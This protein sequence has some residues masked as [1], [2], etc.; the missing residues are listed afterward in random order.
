MSPT[1]TH[2]ITP[3]NKPNGTWSAAKQRKSL[4][5]DILVRSR[6]SWTGESRAEG[7]NGTHAR[8]FAVVGKSPKSSKRFMCP[9]H[10]SQWSINFLIELEVDAPSPWDFIWS[11]RFFDVPIWRYCYARKQQRANLQGNIGKLLKLFP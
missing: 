10:V 2:S 5:Y 6:F 1:H 9:I 8:K 7:F 4:Y 3:I 11:N